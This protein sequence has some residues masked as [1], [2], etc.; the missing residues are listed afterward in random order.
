[1][2]WGRKAVYSRITALTVSVSIWIFTLPYTILR[3]RQKQHET[4]T[5]YWC[6]IGG[7]GEKYLVDKLIGE[8]LWMWLTLAASIL[9]YIPLFLLS[10]GYISIHPLKWWKFSIHR[11]KSEI[12]LSAMKKAGMGLLACVA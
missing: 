12:G 7:K 9:A 2:I 11:N 6:W 8:Y 1:M 5:P 4:P 3:S 10:R